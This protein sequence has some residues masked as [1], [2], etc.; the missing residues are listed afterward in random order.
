M[1]RPLMGLVFLKYLEIWL[2]SF[3]N[4]AEIRGGIFSIHAG[5]GLAIVLL[6]WFDGGM[7]LGV[8]LS[9]IFSLRDLLFLSAI[10]ESHLD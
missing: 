4:L 8:S 10:K 2:T 5:M 9:A 7:I 6:L 3:C 1:F